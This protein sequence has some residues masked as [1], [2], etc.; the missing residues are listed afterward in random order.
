[1]WL[2]WKHAKRDYCLFVANGAQWQNKPSKQWR[3]VH[4]PPIILY[5]RSTVWKEWN[6]GKNMKPTRQHKTRRN[7]WWNSARLWT[8]EHWQHATTPQEFRN[9]LKNLPKNSYWKIRYRW[10][11]Q[12]PL[13]GNKEA[14][15]GVF[16]FRALCAGI[17]GLAHVGSYMGFCIEVWEGPGLIFHTTLHMGLQM[18]NYFFCE[19]CKK[20]SFLLFAE[21]NS[22]LRKQGILN[23]FRETPSSG[24]EWSN[25]LPKIQDPSN[26]CPQHAHPNIMWYAH[27]IP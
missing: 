20:G 4:Q 19:T 14:G 1:M 23:L 25:P 7:R 10:N 2:Y 9:R 5:T 8:T 24:G 22:K 18:W 3:I 11:I 21:G 6:S 26:L 13:F 15:F 27:V 16:L 17:Y 12:D